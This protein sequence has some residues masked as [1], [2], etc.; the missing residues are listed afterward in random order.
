MLPDV[1]LKPLGGKRRNPHRAEEAKENA[2]KDPQNS[3]GAC[4][5]GA[6]LLRAEFNWAKDT[7]LGGDLRN[8]VYSKFSS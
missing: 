3:P 1:M 7:F 5:K 6:L 8:G 2:E 4:K